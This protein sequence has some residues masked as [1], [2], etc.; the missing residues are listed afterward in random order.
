MNSNYEFYIRLV[1]VQLRFFMMQV[2]DATGRRRRAK[3]LHFAVHLRH[4]AY[5]VGHPVSS[6]GRGV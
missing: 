5:D 6:L 1:A 4:R 2:S 3:D